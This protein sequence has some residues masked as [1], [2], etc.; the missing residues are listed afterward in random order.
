MHKEHVVQSKNYYEQLKNN[1]EMIQKR[2]L[3][4]RQTTQYSLIKNRTENVITIPVVI[5]N[6]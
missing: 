2:E 6:S 3:I 1:P 5:Y 4:E